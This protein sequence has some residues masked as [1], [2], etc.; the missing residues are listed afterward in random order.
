[1]SGQ[2]RQISAGPEEVGVMRGPKRFQ[3]LMLA[4][5]RAMQLRGEI[6]YAFNLRQEPG[7]VVAVSYVKLREPRSRTPRYVGIFC[8]V[9]GALAG[10]GGM[11]YHSRH[12]IAAM[13]MVIMGGFALLVLLWLL[14]AIVR[15]AGSAGHCPGAWHR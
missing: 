2:V 5:L 8:A 1:M 3:H 10:L 15:A 14:A 4:E 13:A 12:V 7:D 11:V 6:A 9:T